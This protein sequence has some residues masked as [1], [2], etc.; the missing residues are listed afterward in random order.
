MDKERLHPP[1]GTIFA[2]NMLV[3][4]QYGDTYTESEIRSWMEEVGFGVIRKVDT[5]Y[6]NSIMIGRK[7]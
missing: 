3:A 7:L 2:L 5:P 6:P 1:A 4:R